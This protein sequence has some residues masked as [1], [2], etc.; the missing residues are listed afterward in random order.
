M[1]RYHAEEIVNEAILLADAF[2]DVRHKL[3]SASYEDLKQALKHKEP[4]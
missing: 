3:S 2:Y 1:T 4:D